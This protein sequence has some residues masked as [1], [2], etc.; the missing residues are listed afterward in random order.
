M[1]AGRGLKP[2]RR[3]R[4][5]QRKT[6]IGRIGT[7]LAEL[8][9]G[10]WIR[11]RMGTRHPVVARIRAQH[12]PLLIEEL[13]FHFAGGGRQVEVDQRARRRIFAGGKLRRPWRRVV[14]PEAYADS[15]CGLEQ[16]GTRRRGR[17][18]GLPQRS[19]VVEDPETASMRASDQIGAHA[20]LVIL[21]LN[22][23][24]RNR[25]HVEPQRIP[26]IAIVNGKPDLSVRRRVQQALLAWILPNRVGHRAWGD[27]I[28]DLS[29]G[30]ATVV[31][32]P[33]VRIHVIQTQRVRRRV[34]GL[35]IEVPGVHVE[36]SGPCLHRRRRDVG[37]L[38][39]A[40]GGHLNQSVAGARPKDIDVQRRRRN[41]RYSAQGRRSHCR[42]VL[43]GVRRHIPFLAARKIAAD[44]RPAMP[45]VDGLPHSRSREEQDV[46]ILRRPN[47]RLC[48]HSSGGRRT[49]N[50][51]RRPDVRL[52]RRDAIVDGY[53]AAV[54]HIGILGIGRSHA[55]FFNAHRMP[56]VK[57]NLAIHASAV[58]A[59]GAG[60]LLAAAKTIRKR[61]VGSDV[62]H[63][64]RGLVV[65]VAPALAAIGRDHTALVGH[66][67]QDARVRRID[68]YPLIVVTTGRSTHG[69]PCRAAI[70]SPPEH[71]RAT[72]D[73][74]RV[75]RIDC[76]GRQVAAANPP[77]R[78]GISSGH[79]PMLAAIGASVEANRAATAAASAAAASPARGRG[80]HRDRRVNDL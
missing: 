23:T 36:D 9:V 40:I 11:R 19:D 42:R 7:L 70:L 25:R 74:L 52:L 65:P 57:R 27:S 3:R 12:L 76:N 55:V 33:Q 75:G 26:V 35:R 56:I 47:D 66:H 5:V 18:S 48:A 16:I 59:G 67:Q 43:A 6:A 72:I 61:V 22:V 53:L 4:P 54:N 1:H 80:R 24:H 39:A 63:G 29:P 14:R 31:R 69:G 44:R 73:D 50:G 45:A 28:V 21:Q 10:D 71:G 68:P 51:S 38:L 37:P 13:E 60:I 32:P 15:S 20:G 30:L 46:R 41:R 62:V 49:F 17:I 79:R 8:V 77:Q 78:T 58:D 2:L 64:S 34:G